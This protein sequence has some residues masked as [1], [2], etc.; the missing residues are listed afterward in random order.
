MQGDGLFHSARVHLSYKIVTDLRV[1]I[2]DFFLEDS[3]EPR[4]A[5]CTL[6]LGG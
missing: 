5:R 4:V 2:I 1:K 3:E 6:G